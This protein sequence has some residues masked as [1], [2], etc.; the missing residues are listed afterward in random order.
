MHILD[1]FKCHVGRRMQ[2]HDMLIYRAQKK[3]LLCKYL[4]TSVDPLVSLL[5]IS[6]LLIRFVLLKSVFDVCITSNELY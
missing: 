1:N 3:F 2:M 5:D 4:I 6:L